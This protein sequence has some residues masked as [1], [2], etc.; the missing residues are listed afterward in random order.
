[1]KTVNSMEELNRLKNNSSMLLMYFGG[2]SCGVCKDMLPK[3]ECMLERYPGIKAIKIEIEGSSELAAS[4][5]VFTIPVIIL[6][7]QGKETIRE[8]R[9]ISV[10]G[11]EQKISRYYELLYE[12]N[13]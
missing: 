4:Y 5:N 6:F 3:V 8:A 9:I 2:E 11:L 13:S 12:S 10:I 7:I 1:M